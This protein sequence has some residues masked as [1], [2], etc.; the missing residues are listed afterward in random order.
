MKTDMLLLYVHQCKNTIKENRVQYYLKE[1]CS[2][3]YMDTDALTFPDRIIGFL[4]FKW[5]VKHDKE[6]LSTCAE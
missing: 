4:Y 6:N 3:F 2:Y 5:V 1:N